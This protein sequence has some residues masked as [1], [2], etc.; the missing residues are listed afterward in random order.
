MTQNPAKFNSSAF[1][2]Y[3]KEP[4]RISNVNPTS[5]HVPSLNPTQQ[6][7]LSKTHAIE[8]AL[9]SSV[10]VIIIVIGFILRRYLKAKKSQQQYGEGDEK[11][12]IIKEIVIED[13]EKENYGGEIDDKIGDDEEQFLL[14]ARNEYSPSSQKDKFSLPPSYSFSPPSYVGEVKSEE[15][16]SLFSPSS[17]KSQIKRC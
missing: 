6:D 17:F 10:A 1:L 14:L 2:N 9:V 5:T 8:I 12:G 13:D 15:E 11:G 4:C 16:I 7:S 3:A